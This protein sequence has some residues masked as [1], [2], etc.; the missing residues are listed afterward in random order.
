MNLKNI[1]IMLLLS[2][3]MLS[4]NNGAQVTEE[5]KASKEEIKAVNEY[6]NSGKWGKAV[7]R[8]YDAGTF[9]AFQAEG[10]VEVVFRQADECSV[11]VV[12]HEEAIG[13]YDMRVVTTD[14]M[15][16]FIVTPK[17]GEYEQYDNIPAITLLISAPVLRGIHVSGGDVELK[18]ELIQTED[19]SIYVKGDGDVLA[20]NVKVG[21]LNI[22]ISGKGDVNLKK[23]KAKGNANLLIN[24]DG[25]IEGKLSCKDAKVIVN[26][27]GSVDLELKCKELTAHCNGKG[28]IELKGK[29]TVLRKRDGAN[30]AIDSRK[31]IVEKEI[32]YDK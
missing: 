23:M 29:C 28:D 11:K 17:D 15:K 13:Q 14:D 27:S 1:S 18:G 6:R 2:A 30:G 8:D 9:D 25:D 19:L 32:L 26:G 12:G 10:H 16:N 22:E 7:S 31:L 20:K 24:G 21:S 5:N 3:A 4:C